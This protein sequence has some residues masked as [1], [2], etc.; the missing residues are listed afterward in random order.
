MADS[1]QI[2]DPV[3]ESNEQPPLEN[4]YELAHAICTMMQDAVA[5]QAQQNILAMEA[6]AKALKEIQNF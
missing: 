2:T 1:K 5:K 4:I 3:A 6:T